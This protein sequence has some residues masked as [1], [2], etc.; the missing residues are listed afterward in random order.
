MNKKSVFDTSPSGAGIANLLNHCKSDLCNFPSNKKSVFDTSPS[1]AGIVNLLNHCKSNLCNFLSNKKSV[2]IIFVIICVSIF[3]TSCKE[4]SV[5]NVP[6][7]SGAVLSYW[8][9]MNTSSANLYSGLNQTEFAK[10]LNRATDIEVSFI[11]PKIGEEAESF[12]KLLAS[13]NLPDIV[14]GD[15]YGFQG[16]PD[17]AINQKY[18]I[19]LDTFL[20]DSAPNFVNYL[21]S[22]PEIS[23]LIKTDTGKYYCFP[24]IKSDEQSLVSEGP[25]I[26]S[27]W[28]FKLGLSM[29]E[30]LDEWHNVLKRFKEELDCEAPLTYMKNN[31]YKEGDFIGAF[32][33]KNDFFIKDGAVV[34]GPYTGAYK[35]FLWEFR[36]WYAEGLIDIN[37]VNA[38]Y[39]YVSLNIQTGKSG[40]AV[41]Y[42]NDCS[43]LLAYIGQHSDYSLSAAPRPVLKKGEAPMFGQPALKVYLKSSA[44]ITSACKNPELAVRLLDYGYS[45]D[46]IMLYNF[47]IE[48]ESYTNNNNNPLYTDVILKN[49]NG[50]L[51]SQ[52]VSLY[53]RVGSYG[54]FIQRPEYIE[55]CYSNQMQKDALFIWGSKEAEK[56]TL[57]RLEFTVDE[58]ILIAGIQKETDAY[59]DEM[60]TRFIMGLEPIEAFDNYILR[61]KELGIDNVLDLYQAAYDKYNSNH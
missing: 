13:G 36:K 44:A 54:P 25:V 15:W 42:E 7:K 51:A 53:T 40:A 43:R 4:F 20:P 55:Q 38:D 12:S 34:F 61:L 24:F 8:L 22:H 9:P 29:P 19:A 47:G 45:T 46:G 10:E 60:T 41:A 52:I 6:A 17:N 56:Y 5:P 49:P 28:L 18:I 1:G 26:R 14:E 21:D 33:I 23:E 59:I 3:V 32:G 30:T 37:A 16:G 58:K 2:C 31:M 48:N 39:D 50:A 27:D 35:D 11:H 57:P